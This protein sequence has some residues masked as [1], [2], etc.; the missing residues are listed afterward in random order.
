M[1]KTTPKEQNKYYA[2]SRGRNPGIYKA[3]SLAHEQVN[4]FPSAAHKGFKTL[5]EAKSYMAA[6]GISKPTV[7]I[8]EADDLN[9]S[10]SFTA[11]KEHNCKRCER[12][13][14]LIIT[15]TEKLQSLETRLE[16][17]ATTNSS[18]LEL[19]VERI[20]DKK[21]ESIKSTLVPAHSYSAVA[22]S[23]T[24]TLTETPKRPQT[25]STTTSSSKLNQVDFQPNKCIVI[26][27]IPREILQSLNQDKIR[28]ALSTK[29]GPMFIDLINRYK[30]NSSNPKLI[31]QLSTEEKAQQVVDNW[32]SST[33]GNSTSARRTMKPSSDSDNVGMAKGV[34]LDIDDDAL[35]ELITHHYPEAKTQRLS[36]LEGNRLRTVRIIFNRKD[37]LQ[38]ALQ[39]GLLLNTHNILVRIEQ[40][41]KH[42]NTNHD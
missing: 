3:W 2:V 23:S 37:Q 16:S 41:N 27:N 7:F 24:T 40:R 14:S 36:S 42:S 28:Q 35:S 8:E 17:I 10:T 12:L 11:E 18:S 38:H 31:V 32:D 9:L 29:H 34:P 6:A 21:L 1:T 33:L 20:L 15:L 30:F 4:N 26:S 19:T 39:Y 22:S 5:K 13:E 25:L